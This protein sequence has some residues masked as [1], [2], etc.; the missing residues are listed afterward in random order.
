MALGGNNA[1]LLLFNASVSL[2][3]ALLLP[4]A[5][6]RINLTTRQ[7]RPEA[8]GAVVLHE[9]WAF[10]RQVATYRYLALMTLLIALGWIVF[11]YQLLVSAEQAYA[12][13]AALQAFYG[14][15]KLAIAMLLLVLKGIVAGWLI[16]RL[17]FKSIF[18]LVAG[19]M[20]LGLALDAFTCG[21]SA[22]PERI[23]EVMHAAFLP[24]RIEMREIV[25]RAT[26]DALE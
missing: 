24:K 14:V 18:T 6:R 8:K 15:F 3:G 4:L 2:L 19:M 25:G 21:R 20:V 23:V 9:G 1:G 11:E 26:L 12:T 10:V 7:S 17:G 13:P 22:A 16:K 5:L